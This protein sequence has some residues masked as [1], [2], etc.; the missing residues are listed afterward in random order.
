M[1]RDRIALL[2]LALILIG[3]PAAALG[4]E[5]GLRPALAPHRVIDIRA[6]APEAGGFQPGS[7]E[8]A[9]GETVTLR[10]HAV[11]VTHGIAIGPGL[12]IDLGQVDPGHV[13]EV[14]VTFDEP[15]AY[16]FY[17][18]TWCSQDH[19]RM[20][21][22]IEVRA[23]S[24][25]APAA[26]S[27]PVIE[28][29][30]AEGVDIDARLASHGGSDGHAEDGPG[31]NASAARGEGVIAELRVPA[32]LQE[33]A[34]R[35]SHTPAE[36]LDLLR[37]ANPGAAGEVLADA[38][39][40]LWASGG[41]SEE[42]IDLYNKNCAACHGQTGN[43]EGPAAGQTAEQP[44]AFADATYMWQMR[45]DV[46]YAKIRRGGMGTDMPNF[47]TVF[48][49]EETRDIVGYLWWLAF[50]GEDALP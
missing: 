47:G 34:W 26:G 11:D 29:L 46:L 32:E 41:A 44:A 1:R 22:V 19:W 15:G 43:A 6:A 39:A 36:G 23:P 5:F 16:T 20:R 10:F 37:G 42:A 3:L 21:G 25:A 45:G 24:G 14:T 35:F 4:Y 31:I 17:C 48:T 8:V 12:G 49:R 28:A 40:Y 7:V 9:A 13:E 38:V 2:A 50:A 33:E 27:D 18:N 30:V